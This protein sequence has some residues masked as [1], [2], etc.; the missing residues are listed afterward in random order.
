MRVYFLVFC[1]VN[2]IDWHNEFTEIYVKFKGKGALL[3]VAFLLLHFQ[4]M[5]EVQ[6]HWSEGEIWVYLVNILQ[7]GNESS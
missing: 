2:F 6:S 1:F 3:K 5:G 4:V 7:M